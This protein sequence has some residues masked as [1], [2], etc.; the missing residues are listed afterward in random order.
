ML[1]RQ[2]YEFKHSAPW[3]LILHGRK[4]SQALRRSQM[5]VAILEAGMGGKNSS[6][7]MVILSLKIN[8][9]EQFC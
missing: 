6:T 3:I 9:G 7:S 4:E 2:C 8:P 5:E 1:R